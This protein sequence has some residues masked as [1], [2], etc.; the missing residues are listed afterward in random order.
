MLLHYAFFEDYIS[1]LF[2]VCISHFAEIADAA[3]FQTLLQR[4]ITLRRHYASIATGF[5]L[6]LRRIR[7]I[8]FTISFHKS[9]RPAGWP[10]LTFRI[11]RD[12][13]SP[14]ALRR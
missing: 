9:F 14:E 10:P 5:R 3:I 13:F 12:A 2:S 7:H 8:F 4:C 1:S 6:F 11:R